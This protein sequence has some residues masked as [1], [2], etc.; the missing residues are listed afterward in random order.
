[1]DELSYQLLGEVHEPLPAAEGRARR[2][3]YEYT[4]EGTCNLFVAVEPQGGVRHV[5]VTERRTAQ[6]FAR[7]MQDL[8]EVHYAD[9]EVVRLVTTTS[10]PTRQPPSTPRSTPLPRAA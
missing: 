9:A 7:F 1:M 6:D 3:D 10:T 5:S 4:R 8:L 2:R